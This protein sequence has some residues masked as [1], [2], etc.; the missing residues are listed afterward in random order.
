MQIRMSTWLNMAE[1][2]LWMALWTSFCPTTSKQHT[3]KKNPTFGPSSHRRLQS[4]LTS[5]AF[6]EGGNCNDGSAV[7]GRDGGNSMIKRR[8][9]FQQ[10]PGGVH[11]AEKAKKGG[12]V[13]GVRL[14]GGGCRAAAE[15]PQPGC[16]RS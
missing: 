6:V 11:A 15:A 1:L 12:G 3:Q 9:G 7:G 13:V 8:R 2:V 14:G 10:W 5:L 4:S 16:R